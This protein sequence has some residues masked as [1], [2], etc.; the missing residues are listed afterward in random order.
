MTKLFLRLAGKIDFEN[1]FGSNLIIIFSVIIRETIYSTICERKVVTVL[2]VIGMFRRHKL[3]YEYS[4]NV[5]QMI[6]NRTR[7]KIKLVLS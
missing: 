5:F 4:E 6:L 3:D 1:S 7:Y 2:V